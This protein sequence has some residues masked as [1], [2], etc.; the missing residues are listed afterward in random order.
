MPQNIW[1]AAFFY[2]TPWYN[3]L[4]DG[5][6]YLGNA[7]FKYNGTI[8]ENTEMSIPAGTTCI[9]GGV[10]SGRS[11]LKS[12]T[13][14]TSVKGIGP[15]AF[16]GCTALEAI[17]IPDG[18]NEVGNKAFYNTAWY[19]NQPDGMLYVGNVAYRY[20]G[21]MAENTAFELRSGTTV[22]AD[23]AFYNCTNLA[24]ITIPNSVV[25]IGMKA[26][27]GCSALASVTVPAISTINTCTFENCS[28]L[29]E[30][31]LQE[32]TKVIGEKAFYG[33]TKLKVFNWPSSITEIRD[34]AFAICSSLTSMT[35]PEGLSLFG[36]FVFYGSTSLTSVSFPSTLGGGF[37]GGNLFYG[38]SKIKTVRFHSSEAVP[39][40]RGLLAGVGSDF[41]IYNFIYYVPRGLREEYEIRIGWNDRIL[42]MGED[43][44][45]IEF[46]DPEAQRICIAN[47]D[48]NNSGTVDETELGEVHYP[49]IGYMGY[50]YKQNFQDNNTITSFD[51][52]RYFTNCTEI[53][54]GFFSG[55]SNLTSI[56]LPK[57]VTSIDQS[58]FQG[59]SSLSS[60]TVEM[61]TPITITSSTF[62]NRTNATLYV[63]YGCKVAYEA[64][65]Y[66]KEFKEI[67]EM[68]P[69]NSISPSSRLYVEDTSLRCG[70]QTVIPVL[71]ENGTEYGG[72]QFEVT[73]PVG[74]TLN[75]VTKT[76]RLSDDFVLQKSK[77]GE[78]TWQI[79]LY[80]SNRLSFTGNDGA[81]FTMTVD[82]ADEMAVGN[83][84][85]TFSDIV[86]S[87]IDESQEDLADYSTTITVEKYLVGDA[88]RD[89]RVNVTDIMAVA[90]YILKQ[91][92]SNF[93]VKAA[94]VN[95]DNRI[96]VTDIMGIANIILKVN[97]AQSAPARIQTLDPQ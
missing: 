11:E 53:P 52:F 29:E 93:N 31:T 85:M 45:I 84:T 59:C 86:A 1:E 74:I 47:Y 89:N 67:V 79:L 16:S 69:E 41:S 64:A 26:F 25:T 75:K 2:G 58:V 5:M 88:N 32:G 33:C 22:I 44:N 28:N 15:Y 4:P 34:Y 65:D 6:I 7:L 66:W 55:C 17:N 62:E 13:I 36:D 83:Y 38:N 54:Y 82:V 42:E 76:E 10:F 96:N 3:N 48:A 18:I 46:A 43:E 92:S 78:N 27:S 20:K 73:L 80:N 23:T 81:L 50:F 95:N 49:M 70:S 9:A 37:S 68:E 8:A 35:L 87:G 91:P 90:N 97:P 14:P 56:T 39:N 30:V 71:F 57:T 40:L 94:D 12:V 51:E 60:V 24:S 21:N 61:T 77:T 19:N 72:L 63:P